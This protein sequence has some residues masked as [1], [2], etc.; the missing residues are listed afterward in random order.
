MNM[1]LNDEGRK[2]ILKYTNKFDKNEP[3]N[4]CYNNSKEKNGYFDTYSC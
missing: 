4:F 2:L 1:S 3:E